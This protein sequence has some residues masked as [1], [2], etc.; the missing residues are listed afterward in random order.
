MIP[1]PRISIVLLEEQHRLTDELHCLWH[2]LGRHVAP[3][4]LD[5]GNFRIARFHI[6]VLKDLEGCGCHGVKGDWVAIAEPDLD[7][8]VGCRRA[9]SN[10]EIRMWSGRRR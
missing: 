9:A 3:R 8:T 4:H 6:E 10:S 5:L 1:A 2:V 7:G